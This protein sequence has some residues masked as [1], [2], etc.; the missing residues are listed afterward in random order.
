VDRVERSF[1]NLKFEATF[2]QMNAADFQKFVQ[3]IMELRFPDEFVAVKPAGR[4]GDWKN[5]GLL[6]EQR[7]ILQIYAPEGWD[8]PKALKKIDADFSGAASK[9]GD[10]FDTWTFVHNDPAGAP[11]YVVSRLSEHTQSKAFPHK[12]E[13]WAFGTLRK[14]AFELDDTGLAAL[15]GPAIT[16]SQV[17]DVEAA[18]LA[19]LLRSIEAIEPALLATVRPVPPEKLDRNGLSEDAAL[20]LLTGMRRS[21][22]VDRYFS[23]QVQR[24]WLRDD[25]AARFSKKYQSLKNSGVEPDEIVMALVEWAAGPI[26]APKGQAAALAVVAFFFEQCDIFEDPSKGAP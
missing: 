26:L 19:P 18:D 9:W 3:R 21:D 7:R 22:E 11:P 24:P 10:L 8:K 6:T 4:D 14:F 15:L 2:V 12:C 25:L 23:E 17:L 20:L 16:L 1:W 13:T 5:D